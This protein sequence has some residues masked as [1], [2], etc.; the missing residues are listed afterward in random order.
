MPFASVIVM[1]LDIEGAESDIIP[2]LVLIGTN[3]VVTGVLF[4]VDFV[5]MEQHPNKA[6][7]KE[8]E[9]FFLKALSL[10]EGPSGCKVKLSTID[11]W[12]TW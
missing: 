9:D 2:R 8:Q 11:V 1:K 12:H 10:M 4:N 7:S 6:A 3:L 5:F